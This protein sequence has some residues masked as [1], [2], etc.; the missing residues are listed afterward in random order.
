MCLI[1]LGMEQIA[2]TYG[3]DTAQVQS[4]LLLTDGLANQGITSKGGILAE[5]K[6]MQEQGLHAVSVVSESRPSPLRQQRRGLHMLLGRGPRAPP[7]QQQ[8]A[9]PPPPPM[10]QQV[11]PPPPPPMQQQVAPP[12]PPPPPMQ[13]QQAPKL[14][15]A[16]DLPQAE[17]V[18]ATKP[19]P[20]GAKVP[21]SEYEAVL[22]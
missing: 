21:C 14:L 6:K 17:A 2:L 9:P 19:I 18:D 11:A 1:V 4:V 5:M 22:C 15:L 7:M 13:Q 20:P 10:Q 12:P 16:D 3:G 8:V